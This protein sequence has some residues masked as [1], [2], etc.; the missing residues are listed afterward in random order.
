VVEKRNREDER[1]GGAREEEK[2]GLVATVPG[3]G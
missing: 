3:E 1:N 2:R